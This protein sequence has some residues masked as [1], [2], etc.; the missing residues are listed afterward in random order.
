MQI[1]R[2]YPNLLISKLSQSYICYTTF[3]L[4]MWHFESKTSSLTFSS[5]FLL[6]FLGLDRNLYFGVSTC[7]RFKELKLTQVYRHFVFKW[8]SPYRFSLLLFPLANAT[9]AVFSKDV[10]MIPIKHILKY[11]SEKILKVPYIFQ[12]FRK[13]FVHIFNP[14]RL[15]HEPPPLLKKTRKFLFFPSLWYL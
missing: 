9:F 11:I 2:S 12:D 8:F 14:E 6:L 10:P 13:I 5:E 3:K 7:V 4:K 1:F 15:D